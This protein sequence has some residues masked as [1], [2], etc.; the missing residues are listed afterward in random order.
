MNAEAQRRDHNDRQE[1]RWHLWGPYLSERQWGTVREDYSAN[2]DAWNYFPHAMAPSRAYRWGE[3][4][5][6]GISDFRQRLCFAF[7]FWNERDPILKERL[8]GVTGPQGNHGEDVK[9]IFFF[10]DNTPTHSYMR[11]TYRYPQAPFPYQ[12]LVRQNA[13]RSK[14]EPEFELWDT[15]ILRENR[16]FDITIE[17]AKAADDD[18]LIRATATN[19]GLE[20]A[21]LHLVGTFWFR[22]TWS[23]G[24]DNRRPTLHLGNSQRPGI[25]VVQANHHALG[26][27]QLFCENA[28]EVL[29]TENESNLQLLYGVP[30][31]GP[32]V[33]DAFHE[34]IVRG[35]SAAVNPAR[36]GTKAAA[37][38]AI[39]LEPGESRGVRLR[40]TSA[41]PAHA[42]SGTLSGNSTPNTSGNAH[43]PGTTNDSFA[44]FD[45]IFA[46]RIQEA[47]EF[48]RQL[49]PEGLT[50][51][52]RAIQR[53][54]LAGMLWTK[55]FYYYV[56]E[57]WLDGDPAPPSPPEERNEGR[58]SA[59]RHLHNE[60]VMSMPDAWEYPWYAAWDLAFH[61]IPL[62][63]V[64]PHFAKTQLDIIVREWYQH[65]NGQI[66]AYEW[67]F[68]DVNPPVIS[69]AAFRVYKIEERMTGKADRAFLETVF[70]KLLLNFTWWVNRKDSG[71]RNIFEGGFLGL[72]NIG[73]F[74]R[75]M[76]FPDGSRL[77]QSDGTSWMGMFCLTMM[78]TALELA[79]E[80][81]VYENI[82]TKFFEHFLG[83]AAAMNNA[84]GQGIGLWNEEDEFFY[85]V[86]HTPGNRYFPL[87]VRSLVG[88]M[89]LLAVETLEPAV[90]ET[91]PG[92]AERLEWYLANRPDLAGLVSRWYEPGNGERRLMALTRGH[93][94]KCLLRRMLDP[95]EFLSEYGVRS[96]SKFHQQN[97]YILNVHGEEKRVGYE[98]AE[99]Q[100]NI[101]GGNSNW[102]GPVWFPINFL[103]IESLQKFHHYYGDDFKV[104][105]P[106]GSGQFVTLN[107][108]G[109]EL[110]NRLIKL[111]LRNEKGERPFEGSSGD[112]LGAEFDRERYLF[113]E[114]FHADTGGGLGASHQTGW[115]GLVAKLIQQQGTRGTIVRGEP[116]KGRSRVSISL[117]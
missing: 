54:A 4:G 39:Q 59:W 30:N 87:K 42:I 111:F 20:R 107:E 48:Y 27:Y 29:F 34:S 108:V 70:H 10:E 94:M 47:D 56:V 80:N 76:S 1:A 45:H 93:R 101:F 96:L 117:D 88:L 102:R 19:R 9:E 86:L 46:Q 69:W 32:F 64:D 16:F 98:P 113:H 58:N 82:A 110:S 35:N 8:F 50:P 28:A 60:R 92:F 37:H 68:S 41:H 78:Q 15:G 14:M 72:D 6:G 51:E 2:G 52:Q 31:A 44:D 13:Q 57:R 66:P 74:D 104:E 5:I 38:Y 116:A 114:F 115:T 105:C 3:D 103:L 63:L 100:S 55:Q 23:W 21:P 40:L 18:I 99:S 12:E 71:G 7:A 53:Q 90:L 49:A 83:I 81:P 77:E 84:G 43:N 75:N 11:M 33:K 26:D 61:C 36:T 79:L 112:S 95:N 67:N 25:T 24:L 97:P 109:N 22:N 65:P 73:V 62:A 106:T 85:D 89:P 91:M 17:Y